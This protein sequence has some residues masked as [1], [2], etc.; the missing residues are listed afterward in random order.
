MNPNYFNS[1]FTHA[2]AAPPAERLR[3]E[4]RDQHG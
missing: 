3:A 2:L 4:D 1:Q